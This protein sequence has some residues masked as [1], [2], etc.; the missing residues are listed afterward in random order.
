MLQAS[1]GDYVKLRYNENGHI[2]KPQTNPLKASPGTVYVYGTELSHPDDRITDVHMVWD[3][4]GTGGD[5]RG[6]LLG[7]S[8]FDDGKCFQYSPDS[9][10][11]KERAAKY[12]HPPVPVE[13]LDLWCESHIQLPQTI[14]GNSYTL[15]W[16]WDYSNMDGQAEFYTSC[17][18]VGLEP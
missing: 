15:Y 17:L 2:T 3:T 8:N 6:R 4:A 16:V 14:T 10:I 13:G 12:G 7:K 18:D 9:E 1:S 11:E 5:G